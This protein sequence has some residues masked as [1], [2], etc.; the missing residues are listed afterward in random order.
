MEKRI[1]LMQKLVAKRHGV[2]LSSKTSNYHAVKAMK[3]T[4]NRPFKNE[5]VW[6]NKV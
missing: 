4:V 1:D 5:C 6:T 3:R 2:E